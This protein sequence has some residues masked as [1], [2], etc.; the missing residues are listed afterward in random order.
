LTL[1][2][3][4]DPN[5][6][7]PRILITNT[8]GASA[9]NFVSAKLTSSPTQDFKLISFNL[10]LGIN[11]NFGNMVLLLHDH[12]NIFTDTTDVKRP[13]VIEREWGIQLYLGKTLALENRYFYGKI[14]EVT[15][16]RP[17]TGL[18]L[19][20]LVCVGWGIILRERLSKLVRT[21]AKAANGIDL[22]DTD[23]ST[24]ID[25]LLL[26]VFQDIDHQIDNNI[27]K[28]TSITTIP[29]NTGTGICEDCTAIK[30]ANVNFNI[31]SYAQI[32]SNL[33]GITN[34]TWHID[35]DRNLIVQ[36]PGAHSSGMLF[37]N[38]LSG[39][40]A[41]N[42]TST[43]IG[44]ILNAP[45]SW[46]DSSADTF[47]S[48][49]HG[50]GHF[51]PNLVASDGQTPNATDSLHDI[52]HAI[53]FTVTSDNIF[54]IAVRSIRTGTLTTDGKVEIW[55]AD[56]SGKPD[57]GDIR[58]SILLNSATLNGL[59][60]TTPASFFEIF[61]KPKLEVT[62]NEQLFIVFKKYGTITDTF[63]VDYKSGTG[64]FYDSTDAITW[65]S[66]VGQS[67][68]RVYDA[69]RL[70]TTLENT[71]VSSQIPEVRERAFPIRADMEEQTV[72][73]TLI[74]A[75][76]IL[77]RQKRTYSN[78][79]VSPV[80]NLIKLNTFCYIQDAKTGLDTKANIIG[81]SMSCK[82]EDQGVQKMEISLEE[83]I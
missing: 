67:A 20:T 7:H 59:G 32:I 66:R 24:R 14:K 28:L 17:S 10:E 31:A 35:Q 47:Y 36:D 46:T 60:T 12:N 64:T 40:K 8:T 62:P 53:P 50:Y 68:Y 34:S 45:I 4:Y 18:Q 42:W 48:F 78:I 54:K 74:Q 30:I 51:S 13:G 33:V 82:S 73:Q 27:T 83:L 41:Q 29:S 79:I 25:Q 58:R 75:A 22:D 1:T 81:I 43:K 72:R 6:L 55:G 3:G 56:G 44:Y 21:Q 11:D 80:T 57:N 77:G 2:P 5:P 9:Y 16:E 49:I 38:D 52:H 76:E 39:D 37:T 70:I 63:N 65:T 61:I 15:I 19:V 23:I 71:F 69:R 26:D